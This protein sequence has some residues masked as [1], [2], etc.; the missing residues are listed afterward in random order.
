MTLPLLLIAGAAPAQDD[1]PTAIEEIVV[2]GTRSTIQGSIEAKRLSHSVIEALS[3]DDIGDIPALSIGEALETLTSSAS[4]R[5]QGGATE[6]SIRGMGPF[7]G[8]TV[9]NGRTATNGSGDRSVNFSQFPSELFNKIQIYKTQEASLIEGAVSGQIHLDTLKP[10]EYNKRRLQIGF[11]SSNHP[12]NSDIRSNERDWGTRP[13]ISYID[14]FETDGLGDIGLSLGFQKRLST[15]PEQEFRTTSGWR[16]CRNDPN[17]TSGGVFRT[18]SGNCDGGSGDLRM[19]V[20]AATGVAPDEGVPFIFVPSSRSYRQNITDDDRESFFGALQWRPEERVDINF[21]VQI[22]DR[23]FSEVRNDLVFAEQRRIIPGLTDVSLLADSSGTVHLFETEGRIETLSTFQERIEEYAGGGLSIGFQ[24][25]DRLHLSLDASYSDTFRR[26]D[27]IHTR[28]QSEP[29]DIFGNSTPARTDRPF[30]SI[31]IS[32]TGSDI[33]LVTVENFDVNNHDLFA[34]NARTRIDLNQLRDNKITAVRGDFELETDWS[35]IFSLQGG[36]RYSELEYKQW[37]RVRDERTFPD[38]AIAGASQACRN[39][40]FPERGFL[41]EPRNG[42]NLITNVDSSG[43]VIE[44]GTGSTYATFDPLC[45]VREFVGGDVP[46]IPSRGPTVSNVDV[47]EETWAAYLQAN[48]EG[49]LI[50]KPVRGNFG[51]RLVNTDVKSTGLRTTFTTQTNPDGTIVVLEDGSNFFSVSGGSSYTELLPSANLVMS[52][53]EDVLLRA[54]IFR[55]LSRPDPSDMGFGRSLSVDDS[56]DPMSIQ[57]LVGNASAN[58]N[59]DLEPLTS[60]NFDL[61]LEWYPNRD[62]M[63]AV[64]AYYKRFL[65]GFEN[66][67][68][69]EEFTIDGQPFFADVTVSRTDTHESTLYGFELTAA[70]SFSYLPGLWKGLGAKL[71]LN[72]ADSDFEFEDGIFGEALVLDESGNV[73]SQRVGIVPPADLFGFSDTVMSAQLYY[74]I[75]DFDFQVIYKYRS[76]YFQQ[77]ISTP[78]NIRYIDDNNVLEARITYQIADGISMRIEGINLLDEPRTQYNPTPSNLAEVNS[79]GPRLFAGIRAKF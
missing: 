79:Y 50:G 45:L 10:L 35:A 52:L 59:P 61:A 71:S 67:Q 7:L 74:Q 12:D 47:D 37:P 20:D 41:S 29:I 44:Q 78:G 72:V 49:T 25:T 69:V 70:H 75:G 62:T 23:T 58:G 40:V 53:Q 1:P 31:A 15:N 19:E 65:G 55:G 13:T 3:V 18:S 14:Q 24:A 54:G 28:L 32:G 39:D 33:P 30:T 26:E 9:I 77:F 73:V 68:R 16:D 43:N 63:V 27:I 46:P 8:S 76:E 4:H 51:L 42:K 60:W 21:D 34:D 38:S 66:A 64:G 57:D 6:I 36:V 11:K 22:S 17:N 5:E 2:T 48:Y 56:G